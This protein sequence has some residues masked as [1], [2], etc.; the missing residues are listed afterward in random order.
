MYKVYYMISPYS[1]LLMEVQ[2]FED[3]RITRSPV[4]PLVFRP[5]YAVPLQEGMPVPY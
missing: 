2:E 5:D 4:V 3:G 1:G